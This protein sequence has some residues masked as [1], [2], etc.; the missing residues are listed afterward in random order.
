MSLLDEM[1]SAGRLSEFIDVIMSKREEEKDWEYYLHK[2][3]DKSFNDFKNDI[4]AEMAAEQTFDVETTLQD[5]MNLA[6]HFSPEEEGMKDG[7]I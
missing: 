1:V 4:N 5:S 6:I 2:V 7:T 3:F